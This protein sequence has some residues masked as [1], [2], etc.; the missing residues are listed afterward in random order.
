[1][2]RSRLLHAK[3]QPHLIS[4]PA[5]PYDVAEVVY[6]CVS[7]EGWIVYCQ[8]RYSVPWR[9]IGLTLPVRITQEELIVYGPHIEE[10]A[11]HPLFARHLTGEA[12]LE[13]E[14][15]PRDDSEKKYEVLKT[16]FGSMKNKHFDHQP[17]VNTI[18]CPCSFPSHIF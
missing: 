18:G 1:M 4:L 11:R 7:V 16:D 3:E 14:H 2:P 10:I 8:N 17:K 5:N 12:H 13:K 15:Q 6:R 9:Y